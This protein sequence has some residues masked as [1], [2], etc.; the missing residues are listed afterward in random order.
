M[1]QEKTDSK[2]T[3]K[4]KIVL[5]LDSLIKK[6]SDYHDIGYDVYSTGILPIDMKLKI[7]GYLKGRLVEIYGE[8][9]TGKTLMTILAIIE[10]QRKNKDS[11]CLFCD[12]EGSFDT[13]WFKTLG[14][15]LS[16]LDIFNPYE[17]AKVNDIELCGE[18]TYDRIIE[19]IGTGKYSIAVLDSLMGPALLSKVLLEKDM[20]EKERLGIRAR[21]NNGFVDRVSL[22]TINTGTTLIITNHLMQKLIAFGNPDTTPGGKRLKFV[23]EQRLRIGLPKDK[24]A[25]GHTLRGGIIKNKRGASAG[26]QFEIYL[27]YEEGIDNYLELVKMMIKENMIKKDEKDKVLKEMREDYSAFQKYKDEILRNKI[28]LFN[29]ESK[30]SD[31]FDEEENEFEED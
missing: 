15:D 28:S 6:A 11:L 31:I 20:E 24:T 8:E 7:G 10:E 19:L 25:V 5:K 23:A 1:K 12:A 4:K 9:H 21:L 13:N 27:S 29:Q 22:V 17:V 14:G 2:K 30:D 3:K 26:L 16:R 18:W